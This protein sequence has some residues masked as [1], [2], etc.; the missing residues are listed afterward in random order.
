MNVRIVY[1]ELGET[2]PMEG[3]Q[4][5]LIE[6]LQD[7]YGAETQILR[8]LP[9][10]IDAA[11]SEELKAALADNLD[12]TKEQ[13]ER[14]ER[15]LAVSGETPSVKYCLGMEGL[16]AA[17]NRYLETRE[18]SPL[19]DLAIIGISQRIELYEVAAYETARCMAENCG[20]E[21][22]V[23]LLRESLVEE[24]AADQTFTEVAEH[25]FELAGHSLQEGEILPLPRS[26]RQEGG[27]SRRTPPLA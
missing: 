17:G 21:E 8:T 5:L 15:V 11:Q 13:I 18:A 1:E 6:E 10:F 2:E 26:Q 7:L 22:C 20:L 27:A 9:A 4:E 14:L 12:S 24:E 25:I 19:R 16:L 23:L 3:L